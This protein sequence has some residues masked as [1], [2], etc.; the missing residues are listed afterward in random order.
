MLVNA[1]RSRP[2]RP[3]SHRRARLLPLLLLLPLSVCLGDDPVWPSADPQPRTPS[4]FDPKRPLQQEDRLSV[5]EPFTLALVGDMIIARPL[6]TSAPV[7]GFDRLLS[8]IRHSDAAFGNLETSL[9]D[10][11]HFTG[12][13]YPF[14]GDWAN[15]GAPAVAAD[16]RNMGFDLV[17]RA[18]NHAMDWGLE[19]MRE[20]ASYLEKAGVVYAG[21]GDTA[22]QARA[23]AYYESPKGR[24]ALVAFA[25]TFRPTTEAMPA[26]GTAPGRAGLSAV[27]LVLH[28][29]VQPAAMQA[30]AAADCQMHQRSCGEIP[31]SLL[32]LDT[33]YV[34]DDHEFN[35]WVIDRTDLA[36]IGRAI[37]EARQ[38]ADLVVVAV[39]SHE[40]DWDCYRRPGPMMPGAFLKDIAHGAIDA[41]AD[42]FTTSGIH[43]LGPI[44]I[45]HGRPIFYGLANFFW[46]DIQEPVPHEL[47]AL[48][49]DMLA[50]AYEHPERATDYDLTAPLN[51]A[52]F[53]TAYTFQSVLAQVRFAQGRLD[54]ITLYP[55]WLGYGD[56]LRSSGTPRLE[57]RADGAAAIFHRIETATAD[58]GLPPLGLKISNNI[59]SITP[60][61]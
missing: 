48:N 47:F 31:K 39:H 33:T 50:Q 37:R 51:A 54:G 18:N 28:V 55:V 26:H 36:E 7:A 41:G 23:P 56:N 19:G 5:A 6:S 27:H 32:L 46:S 59:A 60:R 24:V 3:F 57:T 52:S 1:N 11:R 49:R 9:I 30:L 17:G 12:A 2:G 29:H 25:T 14:D 40:C 35:E 20:T 4:L 44:E 22:A 8:V 45:Y 16:L 42:V 21:S 15:I 43:N 53:A 61:R 10:M 58:Y 34:L 38:H 13:P